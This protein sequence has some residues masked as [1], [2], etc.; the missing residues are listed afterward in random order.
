MVLLIVLIALV[1]WGRLRDASGAARDDLQMLG[2][3]STPLPAANAWH[4][5]W[6]LGYVIPAKEKPATYAAD[7]ATARARLADARNGRAL[8]PF[9]KAA[10]S[11]YGALPRLTS[12]DDAALCKPITNCL[13]RVRTHPEA[14]R[15]T[16]TRH[17][18]RLAQV[19]LLVN[20]TYLWNDMPVVPGLPTPDFDDVQTLWLT[21]AAIDFAEGKQAD[22]VAATCTSALTMRRLHAGG[23]DLL[24]TLVAARWATDASLLLLDMVSEMPA[25]AVL[26]PVCQQAFAPPT[27]ADVSLC[28]AVRF[29]WRATLGSAIDFPEFG[30]GGL[31]ARARPFLVSRPQTRR[32]AAPSY[33]FACNSATLARQLGDERLP[34]AAQPK[35]DPDLVDEL[36]NPWGVDVARVTVPDFVPYLRRTEDFAATL[37]LVATALWLR[38]QR[39]DLRTLATRLAMRPAALRTLQGRDIKAGP[40]GISLRMPL[41]VAANGASELSVPL[42]ISP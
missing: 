2:V 1:A 20:D 11:Q 34:D 5:L 15:L 16:V 41:Y 13:A 35:P 26:P 6:L 12:D 37:R 4:T 27:V 8:A 7:L 24:G 21:S 30:G 39:G 10:D 31:A 25:D 18:E 36:A 17:A 28:E 38:D 22:A 42:P 3:D 29:N 33:A 9:T 23:N 32:L 19:R 40:D 14:T